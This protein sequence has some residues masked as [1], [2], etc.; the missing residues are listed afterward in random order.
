MFI[1][2]SGNTD[3]KMAAYVLKLRMLKLRPKQ[4]FKTPYSNVQYH[5]GG[6]TFTGGKPHYLL[7]SK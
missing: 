1:F 3:P 2:I 5:V 6:V 4:K 7:C